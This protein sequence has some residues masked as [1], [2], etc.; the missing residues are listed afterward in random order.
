[1]TNKEIATIFN[2]L[3]GMMELHKE[4]PFKIKSYQNAYIQLRKLADPLADM[5]EEEIS[6]IK[7]VGKSLTAKIKEI[8]ADG[9]LSALEEYKAKT[10]VG[11]QEMLKLKG[12]GPKKIEQLWRGLEIESV[13]ELWYACNENRLVELKG[14]GEKTQADLKKKVEYFQQSKGKFHFASVEP[15]AL[16]LKA[17][18]IKKLKP[19]QI[20]LV[21]EVGRFCPIVSNIEI[22]ISNEVDVEKLFD[23]K[24][25]ILNKKGKDHFIASYKE[26][27]TTI[28]T[29]DVGDFGSKKFKYLSSK[30]FIKEFLELTE[31]KDFK[32]IK[33]EKEVFAQANVP[34]VLPELRD[35]PSILKLAQ[36][37]KSINELVELKDIKGVLHAHST[38]SD[39]LQSLKEMANASIEKGYKYL[40]ITDHSKS[41]FYAN[42]LKEERVVAQMQ[43]IDKLN[44][45]Y[46]DFKIFKGI[47]SDIL[48]NGNLDYE[49]DLLKKFDFIIASIHSNLKMDQ[50]KATTRLIKAIENPYTTILGHPTGR[51]LLS[52]EGYPIDHKKVIDACAAN[53]VAIELNSNPYRLDIDYT[54]IPYATSK[55][56]KIS[57]NPDAHSTGGIEDIRYGLL[58]ARK[59]G[60][61][62]ENCLNVLTANEFESFIKAK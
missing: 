44:A 45:T 39:G 22:L 8:L 17:F 57:I 46:D 24:D 58:T 3:A 34:Y 61:T 54:W 52:R 43:E 20:E 9:K 29:C 1:M 59:G 40:G 36:K 23:E 38:Y 37:N 33:E 50:S 27:N 15:K 28:F 25:F 49:E 2:Q 32:N 12:F 13:G 42:G 16:E 6:S 10:P 4:N 41:A 5:S 35:T 48:N 18:I 19:K 55:G 21:G 53:G 31:V 26:I 11:V 60:L 30:D 56:V 51:L 47:E 62:F 7:G 14:F